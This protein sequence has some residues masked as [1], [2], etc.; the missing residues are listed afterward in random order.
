LI[1]IN[2]GGLECS[3]ACLLEKRLADGW[4]TRGDHLGSILLLPKPPATAP[5]MAPPATPLDSWAQTLVASPSGA[6]IACRCTK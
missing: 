5:P 6:L 3:G 4:G 1:F 2:I